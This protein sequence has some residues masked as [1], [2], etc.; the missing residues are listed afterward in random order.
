MKLS[1]P[2]TIVPDYIES[3]TLKI[4]KSVECK[5]ADKDQNNGKQSDLT[6]ETDLSL[7]YIESLSSR[8]NDRANLWIDKEN[9]KDNK[10]IEADSANQYIEQMSSAVLKTASLKYGNV[11]Y[12][13]EEY[14]KQLL[15]RVQTRLLKK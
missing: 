2:S 1:Q 7:N 5:N 11:E 13:A 3:L 4:R 15:T 10:F 9:E 12:I 8:V 14:V 6:Q